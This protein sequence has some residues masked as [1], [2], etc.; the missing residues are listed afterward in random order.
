MSTTETKIETRPCWECHGFGTQHN[1]RDANAPCPVC[2]GARNLPVPTLKAKNTEECW[3]CKGGT[4]PE[5]LATGHGCSMCQGV[6]SRKVYPL[7]TG[8]DD[9]S[10]LFAAQRLL[11]VYQENW[12]EV[13]EAQMQRAIF[14]W[15]GL[16]VDAALEHPEEYSERNDFRD[17]FERALET[18]KE[19]EAA[20]DR[21]WIVGPD[22]ER[23]WA[24]VEELA[25]AGGGWSRVPESEVL[26]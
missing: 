22:G 1:S 12:H 10:V 3:F 6:G 14:E 25:E 23:R 5:Q 4:K 26:S 9:E 11:R 2:K 16:L 8:M 7:A 20:D 24:T 21:I 17:F 13:T 18:A 19:K 15:V